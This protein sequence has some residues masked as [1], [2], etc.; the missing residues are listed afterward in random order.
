MTVTVQQV[1]VD[2]DWV[3][4]HATG[5]GCHTALFQGCPPTGQVWN[6]ACTAMF[7][8]TG[9]EI[10]HGWVTWDLHPILEQLGA[11]ERSTSVSA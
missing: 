6:A 3:A 4:V 9:H 2:G 1:L 7:Q 11:V 8:V 10:V 5:K